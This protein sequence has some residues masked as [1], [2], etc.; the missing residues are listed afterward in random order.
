M[1]MLNRYR[2]QKGGF[3]QLLHVVEACT[4]E[5]LE[6]FL[7]LIDGED[8]GWGALIRTKLLTIERIF[9][10][11]EG[12]VRLIVAQIPNRL[13]IAA[14]KDDGTATLE[15]IRNMMPKLRQDEFDLDLAGAAITQGQRESARVMVIR[16]V[17]EWT[18]SGH[19]RLEL[20][21]PTLVYRQD[22]A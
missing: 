3:E 12:T 8:K 10:W 11:E 6:A 16:K 15:R 4:P 19:I 7:K 1:S 20:I 21:D 13:L 9:A 18:K 14:F 2:K 22:A 5:K 17:R